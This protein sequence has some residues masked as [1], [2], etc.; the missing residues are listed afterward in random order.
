MKFKSFLMV[1]LIALIWLSCK[2]DTTQP[3][4]IASLKGGVYFLDENNDPTPVQGALVSAQN[5]Y[6][7]ALT[8]VSGEYSMDIELSEETKE[9]TLHA[10]KVGFL[11]S[12]LHV[13]AQKGENIIV[14][15]FTLYKAQEDTTGGIID[16]ATHSGP[17]KHIQIFGSHLSHIYVAEVGLTQAA[18]IEFVV[19]DDLGRH[20]D[21]DHKV[22]V[23]FSILNGPGGGEYL[24]PDSMTT[25]NGKVYTVLNSGTAAGP[26]QIQASF[27]A[28]GATVKTI[29]IRVSI[30][31]GL[32]ENEHF[33]VS[34]DQVN[35]AGR[36]HWGII[37][38]VTAYVGD[39]Y[40][41]PVAPG[42]VV[43]FSTNYGIIDGSA[44][45]DAMGRA[46]VQYMSAAPLPPFPNINSFATVTAWTYGDTSGVNS[47]YDS[48]T[49]LISDITDAIWIDT[50]Y[51]N[52]SEVNEPKHFNYKVRDIWDNPLVE[53]TKINIDASNGTLYGD[54][55]ITLNDTRTNGPGRTEFQFTWT[56]G[57]SLEDPIVFI[58]ITAS[59]PPDGNGYQSFSFSGDRIW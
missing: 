48:T 56:P 18:L 2:S 17:A 44:T 26:V 41:N 33:S 36:V 6:A 7:Q 12:E 54:T 24:F 46:T 10:S 5:I 4:D 30:Y 1:S 19:T 27:D 13:L 37:D 42:T 43:Y 16:T 35:I 39:M 9:L 3:E 51:F 22:N 29:P 28:G 49:I 52:Y 14:P 32:P 53:D 47:L 23:G 40:S 45:T 8:N 50:S 20:L 55:K 31:G 21:E 57:D 11:T 25:R 58:T 15:D 38:N 34:V 59:P